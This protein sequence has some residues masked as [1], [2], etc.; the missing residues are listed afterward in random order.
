MTKARRRRAFL[1]L[2]LGLAVA[3]HAAEPPARQDVAEAESQQRAAAR[4]TA[5]TKFLASLPAYQVTCRGSYDVLQESGQKLEFL[6]MRELALRRPDRL[7][8]RHLGS[9]GN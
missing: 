9:D 3:G 1:F 7:R 6:E 8:V 5:M 4:L 2:I